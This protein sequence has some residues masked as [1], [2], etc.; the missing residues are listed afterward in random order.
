MVI[1]A[2]LSIALLLSGSLV[3]ASRDYTDDSPATFPAA[4]NLLSTANFGALSANGFTGNSPVNVFGNVGSFPS[5]VGNVPFTHHGGETYHGGDQAS[6]NGLNDLNTFY[7]GLSGRN[8][9]YNLDGRDLG[10]LTLNPA[11]YCYSGNGDLS[12]GDLTLDGQG[13]QNA[14]W[15][16]QVGQGL[17]FG[18]GGAVN[19][20]NGGNPCSVYWQVGNGANIGANASVAGTIAAQQ[21]I[22]FG[23]SS[24]LGGRAFSHR[25]GISFNGDDARIGNGC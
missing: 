14:N 2:A 1:A 17:N 4:P 25:G 11:V 24:Y 19:V 9:D 6:R 22:T 16:F 12:T 10:G 3:H 13:N 8:C 7:N 20:Q 23:D 5:A 15:I 18:R 21:G